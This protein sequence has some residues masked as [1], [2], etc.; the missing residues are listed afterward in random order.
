M[1]STSTAACLRARAAKS[2]PKPHPTITT[3]GRLAICNRCL[4]TGGHRLA[5]GRDYYVNRGSL[6]DSRGRPPAA[7]RKCAK[8]AA[9]ETSYCGAPAI[10]IHAWHILGEE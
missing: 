7:G 4:P 8:N 1:S 9:T 2:P 6:T 5:H 10:K 3:L